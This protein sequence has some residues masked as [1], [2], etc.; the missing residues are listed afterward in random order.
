MP[1]KKVPVLPDRAAPSRGVLRCSFQDHRL[2]AK[3]KLLVTASSRLLSHPCS[4]SERLSLTTPGIKRAIIMGT[5]WLAHL[6]AHLGFYRF[7]G[8]PMLLNLEFPLTCHPTFSD[9][10]IPLMEVFSYMKACIGFGQSVLGH[11]RSVYLFIRSQGLLWPP[12]V[13]VPHTAAQDDASSRFVIPK[14]VCPL[15]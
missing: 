2:G 4:L 12:V 11:L 13:A 5:I 7:E 15:S 6:L 8:R 14:G 9:R 10:Q 1:K 3:C